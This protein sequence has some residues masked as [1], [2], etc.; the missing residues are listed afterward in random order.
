MEVE[1]EGAPT[2]LSVVA[3]LQWW[4]TVRSG[5]DPTTGKEGKEVSDVRHNP[6]QLFEEEGSKGLTGGGGF[7]TERRQRYYSCPVGKN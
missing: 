6:G 5:G 4:T 1:A 2:C 3:H 7:W